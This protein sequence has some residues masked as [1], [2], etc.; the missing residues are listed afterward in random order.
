M[1]NADVLTQKLSILQWIPKVEP[2]LKAQWDAI[3]TS[4]RKFQYNNSCKSFSPGSKRNETPQTSNRETFLV[5]VQNVCCCVV[6]VVGV[7]R[8]WRA[9]VTARCARCAWTARWPLR[10]CPVVTSSAVPLALHR[11]KTA[12]SAGSPSRPAS[13]RTWLETVSRKTE[14]WE[15]VRKR[16][17]HITGLKYYHIKIFLLGLPYSVLCDRWLRTWGLDISSRKT[18]GW[19]IVRKRNLH[20]TGLKYYH[21]KIFLLGLPY[22]VLCDRWLRTWGLDISSRKTEG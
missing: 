1:H 22:S 14:G 7:G 2:R 19:E 11:F 15:I 5:I 10:S 16:H 9:A 20:I 21:I 3:N 18:E 6:Q 17:L 13:A 4:P 12:P 8:R